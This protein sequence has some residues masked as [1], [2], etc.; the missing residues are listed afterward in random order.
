[1]TEKEVVIA[2][3]GSYK[4]NASAREDEKA[5]KSWGFPH[6]FTWSDGP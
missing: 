1:M 5:V 3:T 4:I 6:V 2:P